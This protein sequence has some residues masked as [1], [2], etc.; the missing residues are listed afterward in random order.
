VLAREGGRG[1]R[2]LGCPWATRGG[3]RRRGENVDRRGRTIDADQA[4]SHIRWVTPINVRSALAGDRPALRRIFRRA[5]LSNAGDRD[6]LLAHPDALEWPDSGVA[7]GRIR[8]AITADG[9]VVGFIAGLSTDGSVLEVVD[10]FVDPDW[11]R[12]GVARG[13]MGDLVQTARL[14]GIARIEVT[15]NPHADGFYRS[16]G[17]VV[18]DEC[19]TR[20]GPAVRMQLVLSAPAAPASPQTA[21]RHD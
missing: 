20:F 3:S 13:L 10:L 16:A 14:A 4:L 5:S 17:F 21:D 7:D 15:A 2:E 1:G 12:K 9:T 18:F 6:V 19:E 8:V 11:M